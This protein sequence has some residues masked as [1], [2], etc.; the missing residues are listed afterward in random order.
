MKAKMI[1]TIMEYIK[2]YIPLEVQNYF[3]HK[4][5]HTYTNT[6]NSTNIYIKS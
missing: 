3:A 6:H 1:G 2:S 4:Y 5:M